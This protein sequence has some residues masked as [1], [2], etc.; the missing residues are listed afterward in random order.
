[1]PLNSQAIA[2]FAGL[3]TTYATAVALAG[4]D[5]IQTSKAKWKP[6][7]STVSREIDRP[8]FGGDIKLHVGVHSELAF[9]VELAGSGTAGTAP[10][11]GR[12]L[13]ACKM[14]ETIIAS[15]SVGYKFATG[16]TDSLTMWFQMDGQR[17]AMVGCRGAFKIDIN[18]QQIPYIDFMYKGLWVAP[19][20]VADLTP[21]T[22]GWIKPRIV[23]NANTQQISYSGYSAVFMKYMFDSGNQLEHFDNPGEEFVGIVDRECVGDF[24]MLAPTISAK[25]YFTESMFLNQV[26]ALNLVHGTTAG[27]IVSLLSP[28]VQLLQPEYGEDR[29]RASL[30]GKLSFPYNGTNDNEINI[31]CA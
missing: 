6:I 13:K 28:E 20:S 30:E 29:K 21:N 3:E 23:T 15:T 11:Y 4:A 22:A 17:H 1:M 2:V 8:S 7:S 14:A 25:D 27:N 9:R 26:A 10:K 31:L 18:S 12:L 16:S 5:Y 24:K 19:N